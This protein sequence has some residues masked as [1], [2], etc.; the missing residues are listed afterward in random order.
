MVKTPAQNP[1]D[2]K[3]ITRNYLKSDF[4]IQTPSFVKFI[5]LDNWMSEAVTADP[6]ASTPVGE[7]YDSFC[8]WVL[9]QPG[10][11][12]SVIDPPNNFSKKILKLLGSKGIPHNNVRIKG[13][14]CVSGI[15]L[16]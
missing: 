4:Q 2:D 15:R 13:K 9:S 12:S 1:S 8:L 11:N 14:R 7:I 10:L 6:N 5:V 3:V 16:N